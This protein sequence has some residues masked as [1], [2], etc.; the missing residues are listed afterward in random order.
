MVNK[1]RELCDKANITLNRLERELGLSKSSIAKWDTNAPSVDK[2]A[3]VAKYFDVSVDYLLGL[4]ESSND[5]LEINT[6][7][8][9]SDIPINEM[10]DDEKE[11]LENFAKYL[12]SKRKKK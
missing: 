11:E 10:D 12:L 6:L 7:A 5:T 2:V 3:K 1:I 4:V 9:S 8:A